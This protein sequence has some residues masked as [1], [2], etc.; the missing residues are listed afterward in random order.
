V[1][2]VDEV[3]AAFEKRDVFAV[4]AFVFPLLLRLFVKVVGLG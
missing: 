3:I 1:D 4:E 2:A